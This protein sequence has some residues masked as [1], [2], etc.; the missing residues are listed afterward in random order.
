MSEVRDADSMSHTLASKA[1]LAVASVAGLHNLPWLLPADE[2]NDLPDDPGL[3]APSSTQHCAIWRRFGPSPAKNPSSRPSLRQ[4]NLTHQQLG[5]MP[6]DVM[7]TVRICYN[8][9]IACMAIP[10]SISSIF[11]LLVR[12]LGNHIR[13]FLASL[14]LASKLAKRS[15]PLS[16]RCVRDRDAEDLRLCSFPVSLSLSLPRQPWLLDQAVE[17]HNIIQYTTAECFKNG[18]QDCRPMIIGID[19]SIWMYQATTAL[20]YRNTRRGSNSATQVLY[21]R[22][23]A[24]LHTAAVI[25]F[26]FDGPERRAIKRGT[27]VNPKGHP[28]TAMFCELIR[29][30]G[31]HVHFAPGEADAELGRL[32]AEN[33]IDMVQTTDS[34]VFLFGA[35]CVMYTPKKKTDGDNIAVYTLENLFITPSV[36]LT[37]GGWLLFALLAGGDYDPGCSGCGVKTA[38]AIARGSLGDALLHAASQNPV[39]TTDVVVFLAA[40]KHDLCQEFLEDP[41]G[42]LGRKYKSISQTIADSDF[43]HADVILSYVHPVTSYSPHHILPP[44]RTWS[45]ATPDVQKIAQFCQL[46][47]S[48]EA[49]TVAAKFSKGL[50]IPRCSVSI[51]IEGPCFAFLACVH[52]DYRIQPYDLHALMEAHLELGLST[53]TDDFPR[54]SVLRVLKTKTAT[55]HGQSLLLYQVEMSAGAVSLRAKAGLTDASAFVIPAAMCEW[56]PAAVIDYALPGLL[57][58][59]TRLAACKP[60]SKAKSLPRKSAHKV[61]AVASSSATTLELLSDSTLSDSTLSGSEI[62][63]LTWLD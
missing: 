42:L 8:E 12:F 56:I 23:V 43:S 1:R 22:L 11:I 36:G 5:V 33:I 10:W 44:H 19:A 63:D 59:S 26:V 18:A 30:F 14:I 47:F 38:H 41:H 60:R 32:S 24:L 50:H 29:C 21:Y 46:R 16:D 35:K 55:Y 4:W 17:T 31:F 25:V 40:W 58:R 7:D 48:W 34:D 15:G 27:R 57:S 3:P 20:N 45:L 49:S 13:A 61:G 39:P 53:D 37:R 9:D 62:I 52:S 2:Q 54:S 51:L 6:E 28:L